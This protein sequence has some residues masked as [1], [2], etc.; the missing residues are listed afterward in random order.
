MNHSS[1]SNNLA[2]DANGLGYLHNLDAKKSPEALKEAAKQFEALL[3]NMM[4]KSMREATPKSELFQ[5]NADSLYTSMY[6]QQLSQILSK[7]GL[8][9]AD[10]ILGQ[11]NK[12][13]PQTEL[14]EDKQN[15]N[16]DKHI[17]SQSENALDSDIR[18][19]ISA[20]N[21][22]LLRNNYQADQFSNNSTQSKNTNASAVVDSFVDNLSPHAQMVQKM[23]GIPASHVLGQAAIESGWGKHV[24]TMPD[25]SSSY[26]FFGIKATNDWKGKVV[27]VDTTEYI[28][29]LPQKTSSRFRAYANEAEAFTDYASFLNNNPRYKQVIANSNNPYTFAQELRMAGYATDPAYSAKLINVINR[30]KST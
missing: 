25:G 1:S 7:K 20:Y 18:A 26:N 28:N 10:L 27:D 24:I 13:N 5:S 11:L 22:N 4:L 21:A 2:V 6:D 12:L 19:N 16:S 3:I 15:N 14:S 9:F 23:I 29:G 17:G 8:G 30:I